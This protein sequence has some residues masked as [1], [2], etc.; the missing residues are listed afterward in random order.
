MQSASVQ[1]DH[2]RDWQ[3]KIDGTARKTGKLVY[4]RM[5]WSALLPQS[6]NPPPPK[7]HQDGHDHI[8]NLSRTPV[9]SD[10]QP[11]LNCVFSVH[12]P[13]TE[14]SQL[15]GFCKGWCGLGL[16]GSCTVCFF[17]VLPSILSFSKSRGRNKH[18][19]RKF[20]NTK[21]HRCRSRF[22]QRPME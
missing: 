20:F 1:N 18:I 2:K 19:A 14:I 3:H 6:N 13:R 12:M 8:H 15:R 16:D 22:Q 9:L 5:W 21:V 17:W 4:S 7:M 10:P 11:H